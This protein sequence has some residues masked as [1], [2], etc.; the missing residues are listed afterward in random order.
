MKDFPF[1]P[2]QASTI[3]GQ[4]DGLYFVLVGLSL[5]FALPIAAVIIF[6]MVRYRRGQKVSRSNQLHASLKLELAWSVIPLLLG[7]GVFGWGALV[8]FNWGNAPADALE[9][10]VIGKQWMWQAQ[11][12]SGKREINNLH[13]PVNQPVKLIMTS[14]D[15]IHSF[16]IPA[17]R[18]KQDVLPGRY[19]TL[20]FEA[21]QTGD[22]HLFCA[23]YCGTE[24]SRMTGTIT[25]MEQI[26]YQRWL[27]GGD[28]TSQPLATVGEQV[29]TQNGCDSCHSGLEGARG[30]SLTGL[31][32]EEVMLQ[33]GRTVVADELYLRESIINPQAKIAAGYPPIM[34]TYQDV[35]SEEQIFQLIAYIKSLSENQ[36]NTQ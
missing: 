17:F 33:D 25:V 10:Y 14:Q 30:P 23:E 18:V 27:S 12:P 8:Y 36:E 15:V 4:I 5:V 6:F 26:E 24:H 19:T 7:F 16:Y 29:F 22:Y 1:F 31:F 34:P 9:V 35:L 32:G 28:T 21:T 2:E 20:W 3:A 11:H 13:V